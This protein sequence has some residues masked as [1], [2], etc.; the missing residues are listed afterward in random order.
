MDAYLLS[1]VWASPKPKEAPTFLTLVT[2]HLKGGIPSG[3]GLYRW[4]IEELS[5]GYELGLYSAGHAELGE[6]G[7]EIV[8]HRE[9]LLLWDGS[10]VKN[11][12]TRIFRAETR[13]EEPY[14]VGS[15]T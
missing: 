12:E 11:R 10:S 14:V 5:R 1:A 7:E 15:S 6:E 2:H 8:C 13:I 9:E 4:T 3:N